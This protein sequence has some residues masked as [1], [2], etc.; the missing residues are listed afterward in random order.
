[1]VRRNSPLRTCIM[2]LLICTQAVDTT[3]PVLGFFHDWVAEFAKHCDEVVVI[4]LREGE[5]NLPKNVRVLSLGKE[6]TAN[7]AQTG[8]SRARIAYLRRFYRYVWRERRNYDAVF[9]HMNQEYV[10][11][12][13]LLWNAWGKRVYMWRNHSAGSLGTDI[14]ALLCKNIFCTSKHSYTAKYRKTI[15]MPV[16][17][18][19]DVFNADN[20]QRRAPH[21]ILFLSRMAPVKRPDIL[22][23]ALAE[24]NHKGISFAASF[25]GDPTYSDRP[26]YE[27]LKQKSAGS[28]L[29]EQVFFKLGIPNRQTPAVYRAHELFVN[30]SPSGLYDKTIFEAAACG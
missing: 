11:L 3:D 8:R 28:D 6:R 15:L 4:C 2:K 13:G 17:I 25:Y 26:Y 12:G 21:S 18:D 20:T 27:S 30:C 10:L 1:M 5:H 24:L 22:L 7:H 16:G 14:A 19:T 23:G 9:V 29:N